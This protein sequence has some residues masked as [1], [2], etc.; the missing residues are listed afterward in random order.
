MAPTGRNG[1][2]QATTSARKLER[3][4]DG[5]IETGVF[6]TRG[7][8]A[9]ECGTTDDL[10]SHVLNTPNRRLSVEQCLRL[11]R[12]VE[13]YPAVILRVAGRDD[14]ANVLDDLWPRKRDLVHL[15]R[16]ER[17][18]VTQWREL[19]WRERHHLEGLMGIFAERRASARSA[20]PEARARAGR[21]VSTPKRMQAGSR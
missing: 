17:E 21:R 4:L 7:E 2:E 20:G 19:Q 13:A 1:R 12:K 8:I 5:L 10:L 9:A 3:Y 16:K 6:R 11:A 15:T 14:V 18:L